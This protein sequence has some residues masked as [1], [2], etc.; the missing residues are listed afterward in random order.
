MAQKKILFISGSLGLGHVTR[1]LVIAKELRKQHPDIDI[2][3]IAADP[4]RM[5]LEEAGEKL[6]P[7]SAQWSRFGQLVR[8]RESRRPDPRGKGVFQPPLK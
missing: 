5:V 8:I 6:L 7:E 3:W 4:A 2:S 1:D